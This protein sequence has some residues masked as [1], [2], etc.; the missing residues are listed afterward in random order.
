MDWL[1]VEWLV[2]LLVTPVV[3]TVVVLLYGFVGCSSFEASESD[4]VQPSKPA[5][6]D[7]L[8]ASAAGT[9]LIKLTWQNTAG[10]GVT[11]TVERIEEGT[12]KTDTFVVPG[13]DPKFDDQTGLKEGTTYFYKV[14]AQLGGL[15]SDLS[16]QSAATTFPDAPADVDP[17]PADV[18]RI[19]LTWTNKSATASKVIVQNESPTG[20]FTETNIA[21]NVPQ[22]HQVI[23]AEGSEHKFRVFASVKGYQ[24]NVV[25]N[26]IRSAELPQKR[27]KPLAFKA[28]LTTPEPPPTLAGYCIVQRLASTLLKNSGTQVWLTVSAPT[29][30]SLKIDRIYISQPALAGDPWDSA[31][32]PTKVIDIDVAQSEQLSL[33]ANAPPKRLGPIA[34]NL[35]QG[36]DL[37]IAFD[38]SSG[39]GDCLY[40]ENI[41]GA[42]AY[43]KEATQQ[44]AIADRSP[45]AADPAG[46]FGAIPLRHYLMTQ[47][48]VL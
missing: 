30:G 43:F 18:N 9:N 26:D 25:Q 23:V 10:I 1:V 6:P 2:L 3:I 46:T 40:A 29:T 14:R 17:R 4:P 11:F 41:A 37:L 12:G 32:A 28:V 24:E 13:F 22:P 39:A 44:A 33:V 35:N 15:V 7:K 38:F 34:Y 8:V 45:N 20:V 19:D 31:G 5:K 42:T 47:I 21:A 16:D 36:N 27:V 48:E